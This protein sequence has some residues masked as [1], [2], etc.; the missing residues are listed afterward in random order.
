MLPINNN[1][2]LTLFLF[3]VTPN[4]QSKQVGNFLSAGPNVTAR[5]KQRTNKA[6]QQG[7]MARTRE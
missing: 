6:E 3:L 2:T 4:K 1:T 5:R 7:D